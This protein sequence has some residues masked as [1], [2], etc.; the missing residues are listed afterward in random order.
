[1]LAASL[2][3]IGGC[4]PD[5][6]LFKVNVTSSTSPRT[7]IEEC[8]MSIKDEK[9]KLVLDRYEFHKVYGAAGEPMIQGCEGGLTT[10]RI[11]SLSYSSSR[12][13]GTLTFRVN[14]WDNNGTRCGH[15]ADDERVAQGDQP[16]SPPCVPLQTGNGSATPKTYNGPNDEIPVSVTIK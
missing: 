3:G 2:V 4:G 14:A 8:F 5:Y 1:M 6:A 16:A 10:D 7:Q 11:G 13:S 9:D 15:I 12:T